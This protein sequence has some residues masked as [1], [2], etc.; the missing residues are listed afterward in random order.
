MFG[1]AG[2]SSQQQPRTR[3]MGLRKD[4]KLATGGYYPGASGLSSG[5]IDD[6]TRIRK[7]PK[8]VRGQNDLHGLTE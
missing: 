8:I 7:E 6:D 4:P 1:R 3:L 2:P 5:F